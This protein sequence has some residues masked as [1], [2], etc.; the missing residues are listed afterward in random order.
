MNLAG[1]TLQPY[2]EDSSMFLSLLEI[3]FRAGQ[4]MVTKTDSVMAPRHFIS[5]EHLLGVPCDQPPHI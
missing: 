3:L 5:Q 4:T 2:R 1:S